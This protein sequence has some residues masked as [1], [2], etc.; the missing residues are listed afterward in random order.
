MGTDI[1]LFV[2]RELEAVGGDARR[3]RPDRSKGRHRRLAPGVFVE[4][5]AFGE[6]PD[7]Q[8]HLLRARAVTGRQHGDVL[9]LHSAAALWGL[10][11]LSRFPPQVHLLGAPGAADGLETVRHRDHLVPGDVVEHEGFL[12]TSLERTVLDLARLAS[13]ED[14]VCALDHV[15][16][17]APGTGVSLVERLQLERRLA[18]LAGHRGVKQ[19]RFVVAFADGAAESPGESV[20]RLRML[21]CGIPTPTLQ[22]EYRDARGLIGRVDFAWPDQRLVGEFDGLTKY[23]DLRLLR[24]ADPAHAVIREKLR[25]N[26]LR[27]TGLRVVRWTFADLREPHALCT[28][29]REAGLHSPTH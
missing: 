19:A 11:L 3:F 8:Q 20:S 25:E 1:E 23:R 5:R 28:L 27:A 13:A 6:L 17:S 21:R 10:P 4:A 12:V 7:R 14:A 9:A 24:D 15:L 2:S 29:L 16:R 26:R 22:A 18:G